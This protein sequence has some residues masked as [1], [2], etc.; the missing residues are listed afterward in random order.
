MVAFVAGVI[1]FGFSLSLSLTFCL[2]I[3][4]FN[5]C[6]F[7]IFFVFV[8]SLQIE[9]IED[10]PNLNSLPEG[11]VNLTSLQSLQIED[12]PNLNSLPEGIVNLTS[13]QSP[14][15]S[16]CP[17]LTSLPEGISNLTSLQKLIIINT[18]HLKERCQFGED[19]HNAHRTVSLGFF[20]FFSFLNRINLVNGLVQTFGLKQVIIW[21]YFVL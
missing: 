12:C 11:I 10:C 16:T 15:I 1:S 13:L 20:F 18:P 2:S 17:K 8:Q 9:Q 19:W 5:D 21:A 7:G 4:V 3:Q 14:Q 6:K